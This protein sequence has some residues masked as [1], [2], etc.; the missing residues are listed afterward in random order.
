MKDVFKVFRKELFVGLF[1]G[2]AMGGLAA[3]RAIVLNQDP[4]LAITVGLAMIATVF[5]ATTTGA[6]LPLLFKKMKLDPALMSGP[7]ITSIVDIVSLFVYF[8]IA[9]LIFGRA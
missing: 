5:V 7:F 4:S 3:F 9:L 6:M 8:N 1:V 2:V